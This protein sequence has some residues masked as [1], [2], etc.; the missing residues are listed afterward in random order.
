[1]N[2]MYLNNMKDYSCMKN[3]NQKQPYL[4][5]LKNKTVHAENLVS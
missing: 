2:F 1:M 5:P 3:L 4:P